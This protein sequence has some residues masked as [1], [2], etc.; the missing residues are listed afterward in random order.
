TDEE[1]RENRIQVN[2]NVKEGTQLLLAARQQY[3]TAF[4]STGNFFTVTVPTAPPSKS[5]KIGGIL[6]TQVNK[7]LKDSRP[8]LHTMREKFGSICMHGIGPQMW[9]DQYT[10]LHYF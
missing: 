10:P 5:G 8:F 4:L 2:I 9:Q 3:E 7:L 6:T 1:E